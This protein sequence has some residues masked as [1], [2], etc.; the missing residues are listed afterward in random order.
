MIIESL[1]LKAPL[2]NFF[3]KPGGEDCIP[4]SG[5]QLRNHPP[6]STCDGGRRL[7]DSD[8]PRSD[9]G[10]RW[11]RDYRSPTMA[12]VMAIRDHSKGRLPILQD[13]CELREGNGRRY[14]QHR[15]RL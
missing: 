5:R 11:S 4:L 6:T 8:C 2:S 15:L 14:R 12:G 7:G 13:G 1:A 9:V 10:R 3:C